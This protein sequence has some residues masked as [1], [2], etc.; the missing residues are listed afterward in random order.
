MTG[1][2]HYLQN[3]PE[4]IKVAVARAT[5]KQDQFDAMLEAMSPREQARQRLLRALQQTSIIV[6]GDGTVDVVALGLA[7]IIKS[8][9]ELHSDAMM[10]ALEAHLEG[11]A[12]AGE[13][14]EATYLP[15]TAAQFT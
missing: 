2:R 9:C 8:A 11:N 15:M 3:A 4:Y 5:A 12:N 14:P 1:I 10:D 6:A 7:I 13:S